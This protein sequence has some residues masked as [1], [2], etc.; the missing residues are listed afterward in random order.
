ME[1]WQRL[2]GTVWLA[3][4]SCVLIPRWMGPFL[5]LPIH[6][7][8]GCTLLLFTL[9]N[10]KRLGELPVPDRLKRISRVTAG[11]AILQ[12]L[13][14]MVLGGVLH[15]APILPVVSPVLRAVHVICALAILAQASS[16]ATAYDMWEDK[17]FGT[18]PLKKK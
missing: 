3:F 8:L 11:L 16:V 18:I 7:L 15:W 9:T 5:G 12:L 17:E 6:V 13:A 1:L 4:F 2:Y 14:G 10:R